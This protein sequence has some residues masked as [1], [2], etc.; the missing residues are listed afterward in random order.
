MDLETPNARVLCIW[1]RWEIVVY[2]DF[3]NP[4][5]VNLLFPPYLFKLTPTYLNY[6]ASYNIHFFNQ[7]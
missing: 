1:L 4:I 2:F 6:S 3:L 5:S 7:S